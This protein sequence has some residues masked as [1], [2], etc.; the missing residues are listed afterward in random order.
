MDNQ[1]IAEIDTTLN[2]V[3][4]EYRQ[5]MDA[6]AQALAVMFLPNKDQLSA[7][8][9]ASLSSV[10]PFLDRLS[11]IDWQNLEIRIEQS[12]EKLAHLGWTLPMRFTPRQ[13]VELAER[14]N[15]D[16]Q[17]EQYMLDF[18]TL[19][20]GR[21]FL[22]LRS[23]VLGSST[24]LIGWRNLLEQCF[25]AYGRGHY[26]VPIPALL[27]VIEGAVAQEAGKLKVG[28]VDPK[29]HAADLEKSEQPGS[30]RY[31][32]WRTTRV[33]LDKLFA[34]YCFGGPHPGELNRHWILHG[35]DH[36]QWTRT[37]ALQLFNLLDTI[38]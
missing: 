9:A 6:L 17:V 29:K 22:D 35:R 5:R 28:Q 37:D 10:Q 21:F 30:T 20:G 33:V 3:G 18:F 24:R 25:D 19:E 11:R 36:T 12:C 31:L 4:K 27:S 8:W 1:E 26:L 23:D 16:Q 14:G 32:V 2:A 38:Q 15:S 34:N 7:I 13:L